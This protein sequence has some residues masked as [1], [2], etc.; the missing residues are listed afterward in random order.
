VPGKLRVHTNLQH[1]EFKYWRDSLKI[2]VFFISKRRK[3][4]QHI[5]WLFKWHLH[6]ETNQNRTVVN[7]SSQTSLRDRHQ[8][9]KVRLAFAQTLLPFM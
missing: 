7:L 2:H 1:P 3:L 8:V 6:S 5:L 9:Q 4:Q